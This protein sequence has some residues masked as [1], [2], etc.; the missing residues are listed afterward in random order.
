MRP[1][2]TQ[3]R[4]R[5]HR[6]WLELV[7]R[8][9]PFVAIP[10]I[11]RVWPQGMPQLG[12]NTKAALR[13][14]K[15]NFDRA[16]DD[17]SKAPADDEAAVES[18]R[19]AR[20]KW[21]DAVLRD[22]ARWGAHLV[23]DDEEHGESR[24]QGSSAKLTTA[25]NASGKFVRDGVASALVMVF[26]P[27]DS[28]RDPMNDSWTASPIDRMDAL[29]RK[30]EQ[31]V[32]VL[33]DGRW[34]AIVCAQDG[35]MTASG[36]VDAQTWIEESD[37][38]DAFLE[39]I[40]PQRL[41]GG[42][43]KDRLPELFKESITA[44][45][46]ITVALGT[47]VRRAVELLV[48]AFS[49]EAFEARDAG[50]PD[51]LPADRELVYEG[52]VT[53]MMRVVF[54]LFAE[55]RSMMPQSPLFTEAYGVS[56]LLDDLDKRIRD[57]G[58]EALDATHDTW[59][60]LLATSKA[61]YGGVTSEDIRL[62]A[63]GGSLFDPARFTFLTDVD[64]RGALAVAV[65]DRVMLE[66]LRAV[67]YAVIGTGKS[68]ERRRVS[69]RDVDVEQIGYIYEGLLGYTAEDVDEIV[70][71]LVGKDGE[72]PEIPLRVLE[73]LAE[74]NPA[75][76]KFGADVIAWVKKNQPAATTK[77][78][79]A[80]LKLLGEK[81]EDGE[82]ALL[83]V[84]RD[85]ALLARLRPFLGIIRRDLRERPVVIQ[86]GGLAVVE[87]P[88]RANSG[89]HYTPKSLAQEV[90]RYALEPLVFQ[91][92]PHQ[93]ADESGW[94]LLD[95]NEILDLKV[96]DIAC[97]S[98]AFLVAAAEFL[99][100]KVLQA[101]HAEGVTGSAH[102]LETKAR[103]QVVAQCLYGAD[104]NGMAVEM[105]KISLWLVSLDPK[106]P[107]SFVDDKVLH[108][109]SLLGI[110]DIAQLE[111]LHIYPSQTRKL[112][113]KTQYSAGT[114]FGEGSE[115]Q[116][117]E[118]L[119]V[120]AV[121]QKAVKLRQRL[122]TEVDENDPARSSK[123]KRRL[124]HEY[125]ELTAQMSSVADGIIAVSLEEGGK[126]GKKLNQRYENFRIAVDRA[127][128]ANGL[129]SRTML[130]DI[131][132]RGL[133]PKAKTDY[134]RWKPLHWLLAVPDV[135]ER[136]GF[137]GLIGNPAFLHSKKITT[138]FGKNYRDVLQQVLANGVVGDADLAA[139]FLLR[140]SQLISQTGGIGIVVTKSILQS[141]TKVVGLDQVLAG[142]AK[143]VRFSEPFDWGPSGA[144]VSVVKIWITRDAIA[145]NAVTILDEPLQPVGVLR[146]R[147]YLGTYPNGDGFRVGRQKASSWIQEDPGLA[148]ALYPYI[149]A[150]DLSQGRPS[151]A[152]E[153]LID[154]DGR[155]ESEAREFAVLWDHLETHQR[156]WHER[157]DTNT[158]RK[159][160]WWNFE[161]SAGALY[162]DLDEI[163]RAIAFP[164]TSNL[165]M[166][167]WI[168]AN[169]R[170]DMGVVVFPYNDWSVFAQL[171]SSLH[172][173]WVL[174][175][176]ATTRDDPSYAP[177]RV[178]NT[179][180]WLQS[181][182]DVAAVKEFEELLENSCESRRGLRS[183]MNAF[184]EEKCSD[185]DIVLLREKFVLLDR[186]TIDA[187]GWSD[188]RPVYGFYEHKN[189]TRFSVDANSRDEILRRLLKENHLR[190]ALQS[191]EVSLGNSE[192]G[193]ED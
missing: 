149:R 35:V 167:R 122:A 28:L 61:L 188:L 157:P 89:A 140:Q 69:F 160:R 178:A 5:E 54:L 67:Q 139:Y 17:W 87:T 106:L 58:A 162:R 19:G 92:G 81:V 20:N 154:L 78:A 93:T 120:R 143:L 169:V 86:P 103:R 172:Y 34:W 96:A 107:F 192:D 110:T 73:K 159:E 10:A 134:G 48:T 26:D 118:V 155:P 39:L 44:A 12:A 136:G 144:S 49:E 131:I 121:I 47:Q 98:G 57:E 74:A 77:S 45:E 42:S 72:E 177:K 43:G 84:T 150:A 46:D 133:T 32:G 59:H 168:P 79:A 62:P 70:V 14:A 63:Y 41:A 37:V 129:G 135:M 175:F 31:K 25:D 108:G 119:D 82:H 193:D 13:D 132:D 60:R 173:H 137:D 147:A 190:A 184:N 113:D 95:S 114:L 18:Y 90:V 65:S 38:R 102:E 68:A 29:L 53:A 166:P 126:P 164:R 27:V 99:A 23:W 71:G 128:A 182:M 24:T 176:G 171:A 180:P 165:V 3:R 11:K 145:G 52:A 151:E 36:I 183:V 170:Y 66:V 83:S 186:V 181:D 7:D 130:D 141:H 163:E 100:A 124:W 105:C 161:R 55:E 2:S 104:I 97:G 117:L 146:V 33:T 111:A 30:S 109:N 148:H 64:D 6:D 15:P 101:W 8:D 75:S 174:A 56:G 51:P 1:R 115:A 179:F 21:I 123:S 187:F 116:G 153:Y 4:T 185:A 76:A 191:K 88:S 138:A 94:K 125:Q 127:F 152:E 156:P 158:K 80:L 16:W 22:V 91:P 85:E 40:S 142:G 189:L 9:G 112:W 50:W